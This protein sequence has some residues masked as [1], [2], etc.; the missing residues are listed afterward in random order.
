MIQN[1]D[2]GINNS[3]TTNNDQKEMIDNRKK[4]FRQHSIIEPIVRNPFI[5]KI[6]FSFLDKLMVII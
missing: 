4:I 3:G 2:I 6:K 1:S 5:N